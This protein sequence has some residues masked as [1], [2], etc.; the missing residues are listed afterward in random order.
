MLLP[1]HR[2]G[3]PHQ[4]L[5]PVCS[6]AGGIGKAVDPLL[7]DGQPFARSEIDTLGALQILK[8]IIQALLLKLFR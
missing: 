6:H 8:R 4:R 1:H 3:V 2:A 5:H 7:L